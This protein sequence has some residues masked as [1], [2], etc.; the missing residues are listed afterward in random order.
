MRD[1]WDS[2]FKAQ[3]LGLMAA[4]LGLLGGQDYFKTF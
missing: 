3:G 4:R 1:I 2:G